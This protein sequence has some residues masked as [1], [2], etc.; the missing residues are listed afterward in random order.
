[1]VRGEIMKNEVK[2]TSL[3]TIYNMRLAGYLMQRG[4]PLIDI[5]IN[6]EGRNVFLFQ[7]TPALHDAMDTW[8]MCRIEKCQKSAAPQI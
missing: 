6:K 4:L 7:N 8:M 3:F 5:V 2:K 1:M